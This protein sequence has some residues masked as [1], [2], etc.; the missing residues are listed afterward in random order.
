[1]RP[2]IAVAGGAKP[3]LFFE[4]PGPTDLKTIKAQMAGR[5]F[6][7]KIILGIACRCL[8]HAPSVVLCRPLYR[9]KPFPTTF[10]LCCPHAVKSCDSLEA[11]GGVRELEVFLEKMPDAWRAY[12]LWHSLL[13]IALVSKSE[14]RFLASRR[15]AMW[16]SIRKGRVGGTKDTSKARV[17][18]LHLQTASWLALG[19]HPAARWLEQRI[20]VACGIDE[21]YYPCRKTGKTYP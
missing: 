1:M 18:C 20:P 3:P 4:R 12:E 21:E 13:R 19:Y 14:R 17:K 15:K 11:A 10:W 5:K 6:D 9:G 7:E 2:L 16:E 8:W